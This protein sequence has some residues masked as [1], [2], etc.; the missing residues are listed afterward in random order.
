MT[1]ALNITDGDKYPAPTYYN[2]Y[3][4]WGMQVK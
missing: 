4:I 1:L 2:N 3:R